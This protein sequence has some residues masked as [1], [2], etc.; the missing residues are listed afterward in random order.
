MQGDDDEYEDE[1]P[2]EVLRSEDTE[3][4]S[5]SDDYEVDDVICYPKPGSKVRVSC[6]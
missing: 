1:G 6:F 4:D 3:R 2:G 5:E